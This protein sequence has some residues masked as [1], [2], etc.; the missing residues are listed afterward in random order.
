MVRSLRVLWVLLL[1][2]GLGAC[3]QTVITHGHQLIAEDVDRIRPGLTTQGEVVRILGTPSTRS[4][5]D[6]NTWL[7]MGRRVEERTIFNRRLAAQDSLRIR[8]DDIGVVESIERF[9]VAHGSE[10]DPIDETT[11]TGGNEL[12]IV[13]QLLGNIGRFSNPTP[14]EP[15]PG[16]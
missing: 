13:E 12:S 15:R 11:P 2:V 6:P 14:G 3:E 1:A 16:L 9:D 7:Y 10:I 5:F 8:F 4:T